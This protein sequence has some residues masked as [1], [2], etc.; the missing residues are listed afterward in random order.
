MVDIVGQ[1]AIGIKLNAVGH[2]TTLL[3]RVDPVGRKDKSAM[4]S[5]PGAG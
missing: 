2:A 3:R 5:R 1:A 4:N